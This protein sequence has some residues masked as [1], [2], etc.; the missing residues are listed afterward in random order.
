[1]SLAQRLRSLADRFDPPPD[2]IPEPFEIPAPKPGEELVMDKTDV[3]Q[4]PGLPGGGFFR[5]KIVY[6][7]PDGGRREIFIKN[8]I[9]RGARR[10]ASG[11][12]QN[13]AIIQTKS[14]QEFLCRGG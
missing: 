7:T 13:H 2:K 1:M 14:A 5:R 3:A 11:T 10:D 9:A 12:S 6:A 4:T 8:K